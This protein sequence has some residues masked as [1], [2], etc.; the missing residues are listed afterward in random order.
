MSGKAKIMVRVAMPSLI[1]YRDSAL[2]LAAK[3]AARIVRA[4][5][6]KQESKR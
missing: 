2:V 5:R 6:A 4:R 1:G 3:L